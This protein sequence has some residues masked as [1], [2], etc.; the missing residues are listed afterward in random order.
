[1][2]KHLITF[3][4]AIILI[5]QAFSSP[6]IPVTGI[7]ERNQAA[8]QVFLAVP[9]GV[10]SIQRSTGSTGEQI[11]RVE[12]PGHFSYSVVKQPQN[13]PGFV[14]SRPD[15]LTLFN[16]AER[17]GTTGFL[18][19]NDLAGKKF[20]DLQTEERINL[21]YNTQKES[22]YRIIS[23]RKFQALSPNSPYS[24]FIDLQ[25]GRQYSASEL[26]LEIYGPG[27]RLVIQTCLENNGNL[28]WGRMFVT[29]VEVP[30]VEKVPA[31]Y[32]RLGLITLPN[33]DQTLAAVQ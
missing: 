25:D 15:T 4:A 1:M 19:H 6:L 13:N 16:L 7:P 14:S 5:L 32:Y 29:A 26:F 11:V 12:A 9:S 21:F 33:P 31:K 18:A 2:K 24:D 17:Y 8:A 20:V 30:A 28:T 3:G 22:S 27:D 10:E 23:I